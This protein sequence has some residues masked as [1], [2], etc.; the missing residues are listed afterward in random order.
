MHNIIL[1]DRCCIN[2]SGLSI[3]INNNVSARSFVDFCYTVETPQCYLY[4]LTL[5]FSHDLG[6]YD[7]IIK[8][9]T[10]VVCCADHKY[11]AIHLRKRRLYVHIYIFWIVKRVSRLHAATYIAKQTIQRTDYILMQFYIIIM[12]R[13]DTKLR[14]LRTVR[15]A[16]IIDNAISLETSTHMERILLYLFHYWPILRKR[17]SVT[18]VKS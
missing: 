9:P 3:N 13:K 6:K 7:W 17:F 8:C 2:N 12:R 16:H 14:P 11:I 15:M 1:R 4:F 10:Y 5:L 18:S